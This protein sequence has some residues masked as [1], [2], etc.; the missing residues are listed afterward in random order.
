MRHIN[1][2]IYILLTSIMTLLATDANA[3]TWDFS[4]VSP[5]DRA[6]LS[7]DA[8][9][10]NHESTSS[11]DRYKNNSTYSTEPLTANNTELEYTKGLLFTTTQTDAIRIDVK[12][13]RIALNKTTTVTVKNLKA[14]DK[15][16]VS[17]KT[18]SKEQARGLNVTN[19]TPEKG[20][21]NSTSLD[22]Q[23]NT[24]IITADG[25]ITLTNTGGLYVYSIKI[26]DAGSVT[27]EPEDY[28]S[29]PLN[30]SRNQIRLTVDN[31]M[32]YYNTDDISVQMDRTNGT[33][34]ITPV[35]GTWE[36]VFAKTV[37]NISFAKAEKTGGDGDIDNQ[38]GHVEI[39]KAAG[40]LESAYIRWNFYEGADSYNVYIKGGQ[41]SDYTKIDCQLIRKYNDYGRADMVGLMA[42]TYSM[43][44]VP[45]ADGK[46]ITGA[47]SEATNMEVAAYDRSGFAHFNNKG[48]GAY[49]DDGT[50][51][52]DA[53]VL[54]ITDKNFNTITQEMTVGK[55]TEMRT[56]L[57]NIL[58]AF[59]KGTETR[60]FAIR[61][62]G[63]IS[64]VN[65][66]QLMGEANSLQ[67]KGK[68][69]DTKMNVTF[70]G[71]GDDA[72][73]YGWG[74]TLAKCGNIE[75]RNI[76][77]MLFPDD[78]IQLKEGSHVWVHHNDL[79]YGNTGGDSD[80]AK[81]DGS[82]DTKDKGTY[83]TF[84]YNHFWDSGKCSLCG[85]KS[86][87]GKEFESYHH[88]WF[89]HS[90]SRHPRVRSKSVHVYNNYYDGVSKY[91][92]GATMGSSV[93]VENNYYRNSKNPMLISKQGR[94]AM[95][96]G[97][98]S[99]E[100]G[101][102]IKSFGNIYAEQ[103]TS[104]SYT[105]IT[106]KENATSFDCYEAE[107]REEQVPSSYKTLSGGTT[108]NNF[109]TDE[110]LMYNYTPDA[111]ADV[112]A[113][114]TGFYGAGRMNHGDFRWQFDN[115]KDDTDYDV[116]SALKTALRNYS[117]GFVGFFD[118]TDNSGSEDTGEEGQGGETGGETET[119]IEGTVTCSF[120][121]EGNPSNTAFT[122]IANPGKDKGTATVNGITYNNC[123]KLEQAT[124][125]KFTTTREM[126]MTLWF[127]SEDTKCTIKIDGKKAN[128]AGA[129]IDTNAKT[130]TATLEAG[131]HE[132]TK[133]DS[134][135]LFFIQLEP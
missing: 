20:Y 72:T 103:G 19:I 108:Y 7:A 18:S 73:W 121:A 65:T 26:Q 102:M 110:S 39:T 3:Q 42:G 115:T 2:I 84:A 47:A 97:T 133:Q 112:P 67:L 122:V 32:L 51:K 58:Q 131:N 123:I 25:D 82:L 62:I 54:Y 109:D 88:N 11:N 38:D 63:K 40:W 5:T 1:T 75:V 24:G 70:E 87:S 15:I 41:F 128:E 99:G 113:V 124:S 96:D 21:F 86:E 33:V 55:N 66:D 34:T 90:D 10:W 106:H 30:T 27:P 57:G 12:G 92:V 69:G 43:K 48:V 56:G 76:A 71:I 53:V 17:C 83:N 80:Q 50:L 23:T 114:V 116:N 93:F 100:D 37:S 61:F 31:T 89:D 125:I 28:H 81:G 101:G 44:V 29:V 77:T 134:G 49:N 52:Q 79:F 127:R 60:P 98:F 74:L 111:T 85:M 129:K 105:P 9:N 117:N 78:G 45:A 126:K 130:L 94:D 91:G 132:L 68:S 13:G 104:G 6:N 107:S 59:E 120:D 14:G 46:E 8:A 36:D 22:D 64:N 35:N 4:T 135:N 118:C 119:P 16:T 95:G